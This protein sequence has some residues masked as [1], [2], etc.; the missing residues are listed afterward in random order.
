MAQKNSVFV[1]KTSNYSRG[2]SEFRNNLNQVTNLKSL[3]IKW[4]KIVNLVGV[5]P[6]VALYNI[7]FRGF[8]DVAF[9]L[10]ISSNEC[11]V[12]DRAAKLVLFVS[13]SEAVD[14]PASI[15]RNYLLSPLL[16]SPLVMRNSLPNSCGTDGC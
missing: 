5:F 9:D 4:K 12:V 6:G 11:F 16:P 8:F 15:L 3:G 13:V 7:D 14:S 2:R 10:H 1:W